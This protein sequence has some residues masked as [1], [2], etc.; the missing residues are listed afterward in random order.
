[1]IDSEKFTDL[2]QIG[3]L[4]GAGARVGEAGA[5][6]GSFPGLNDGTD[7]GACVEGIGLLFG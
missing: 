6:E 1:M 7:A 5:L 4:P 3:S 2:T